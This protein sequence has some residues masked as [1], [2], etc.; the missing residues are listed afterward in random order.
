MTVYLFT[1]ATGGKVDSDAPKWC[2]NHLV[3]S[4]PLFSPSQYWQIVLSDIG[5]LCTLSALYAT[6]QVVGWENVALLWCALSLGESL[7]RPH[8][9]PTTHGPNTATLP[10]LC[11]DV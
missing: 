11:M 6:A 3:P 10:R 4:S 7:A 1:N 8:Y 5:L 9:V 2:I